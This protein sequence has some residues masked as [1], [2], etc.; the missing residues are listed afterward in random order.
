MFCLNF[1]SQP[2]RNW[3]FCFAHMTNCMIYRFSRKHFCVKM[4]DVKLLA[5]LESLRTS[6]VAH[7]SWH[8]HSLKL[9]F[10]AGCNTVQRGHARVAG[11][12]DQEDRDKTSNCRTRGGND[13]K[14]HAPPLTY[15]TITP[16]SGLWRLP[17]SWDAL[18]T[19][20]NTQKD[21]WCNANIEPEGA[22]Y[23]SP[24]SISEINVKVTLEVTVAA[25]P[26]HT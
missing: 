23:W 11:G 1:L 9:F 24:L 12:H 26:A 25:R 6:A 21:V 5:A 8:S 20:S 3:Y 19:K 10:G 14:P 18:R 15:C 17:L 7:G 4:K 16:V 2:G 13:W 22:R